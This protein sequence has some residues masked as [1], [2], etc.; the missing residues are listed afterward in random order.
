MR[1][2]GHLEAPAMAAAAAVPRRVLSTRSYP[3]HRE[4]IASGREAEAFKR[5]QARSTAQL[6]FLRYLVGDDQAI[7]R[8]GSI[9]R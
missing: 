6:T 2:A 7:L 3:S 8:I 4:D 9:A 5:N 1:V